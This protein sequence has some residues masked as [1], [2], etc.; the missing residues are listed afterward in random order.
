MLLIK[1][2][3]IT[4][5]ETP[6]EEKGMSSTQIEWADKT[7]NPV[8][9]CSHAG[10]PGCDNC[11]ARRM[12]ER[13]KSRFGYPSDDSFQVTL[14][15][16][17]LNEPMKWK[18]PQRIFVCSMGDLFHEKVPNE[19]LDR[20]FGIMALASQHTFMLLTK[21]PK[22]AQ[23]Y[24]T[25]A[26]FDE[27]CTYEGWYEEIY[28]LGIGDSTPMKNVWIGVTAENQ[29]QAD[30]R[31]SILLQIQAA[32]RFVSIE[33]MLG[34]V[35]LG[36]VLT[37]PSWGEPDKDNM[38]PLEI[39]PRNDLINWVICGGETGPGARPI[40]PEWVRDLRDQCI[41][42]DVPFFFK[43]W[44]PKGGREIDGEIWERLPCNTRSTPLKEGRRYDGARLKSSLPPFNSQ[45]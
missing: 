40:K 27:N 44:G 41:A 4:T 34:P 30:T 35:N 26:M 42:A 12:A 43:K 17:R 20:L 19:W 15:P 23:D 7:W 13:L 25:K 29:E 21:R 38:R 32:V 22:R 10:S 24:I 37:K 36:G 3:S 6:I 14:H 16:D 31:I 8:T 39:I 18:K 1:I 28:R 11:Y 45:T 33:P 2:P 5:E 9:G